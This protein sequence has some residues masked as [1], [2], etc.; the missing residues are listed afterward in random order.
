MLD[1]VEA[2]KIKEKH[3]ENKENFTFAPYV[4]F[5]VFA[6]FFVFSMLFLHFHCLHTVQSQAF[7]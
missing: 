1:H 3:W 7:F 5:K 6:F 2:V 4:L